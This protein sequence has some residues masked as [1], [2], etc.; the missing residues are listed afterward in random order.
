MHIG[1]CFEKIFNYL[2]NFYFVNE[3]RNVILTL[4]PTTYFI[5]SFHKC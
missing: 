3:K 5:T 1:I 4:F 2:N